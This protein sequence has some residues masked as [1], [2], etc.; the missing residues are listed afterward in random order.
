ML[1][2]DISALLSI[3]ISS[4]KTLL[5]STAGG[6]F[7]TSF[8]NSSMRNANM[9]GLWVVVSVV[10]GEDVDVAHAVDLR[11]IADA[12][13]QITLVAGKPQFDRSALP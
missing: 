10:A 7:F 8:Q 11:D 4:T 13:V 3:T 5:H 2:P 1:L 6:F 12:V 9:P